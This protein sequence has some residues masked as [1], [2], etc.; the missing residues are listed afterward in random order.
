MA[1]LFSDLDELKKYLS[2]NN[3]F[4]IKSLAPYITPAVDKYIK[5]SIS[6]DQYDAL[7]TAYEGTPS[8]EQTA[9]IEKLQPALANFAMYIYLPFSEVNITDAGISRQESAN[10]KTAYANQVEKLSSSLI[11][12]GYDALETMLEFMEA[13]ED[14]YPLW[15]ASDAY[16]KNKAHFIN[17]S[18]EF[19]KHYSIKRGRQTF[20]A[21]QTVME[22]VE[23]LF[24][25]PAIG[26]DYYDELLNLILTK[27]GIPAVDAPA[28]LL[29]RKALAHLTISE[30]LAQ[31][32]V[33]LTAN[34]VTFIEHTNASNKEIQ[35]TATNDQMS[36]KIRQASTTGHRYLDKLKS[37]LDDNLDDYPT[38]RDDTTVNPVDNEIDESCTDCLRSSE[39]CT[40]SSSSGSGALYRA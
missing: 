24:I 1:I 28:L 5:E 34:G 17:D 29:L 27:A 38:Y 32:W 10:F 20:R 8:A 18:K 2:V 7:V 40:C 19:N 39:S 14:D 12:M 26:V 3:S 35:K 21:I 15:V 25:K 36:L 11:E 37:L 13:N 31:S 6:E 33:R 4:T 23:L 30:A 9:L 22:D 16:T